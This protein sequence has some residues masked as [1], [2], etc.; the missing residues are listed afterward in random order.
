MPFFGGSCRRAGRGRR[1]GPAATA[2]RPSARQ[3][4]PRR[5]PVGGMA[6]PARPS[7]SACSLSP[8]ATAMHSKH[9]ATVLALLLA[10]AGAAT[11]LTQPGAA[12]AEAPVLSWR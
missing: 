6:L 12:D 4:D 3:Y 1:R 8:S 2:R 7:H 11:D 9:L 10:L 5:A